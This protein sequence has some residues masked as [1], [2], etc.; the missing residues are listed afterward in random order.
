ML[1]RVP[2]KGTVPETAVSPQPLINRGHKWCE[3]GS[4]PAALGSRILRADGSRLRR[5]FRR[6]RRRCRFGRVL[7]AAG[8]CCRPRRPSIRLASSDGPAVSGRP[9]G[10]RLRPSSAHSTRFRDRPILRSSASTRRTF[11]SITSPTL[12]T[13][14]GFSTL[15]SASSEMCSS[16]PG[17]SPAR[18]RRRS[19]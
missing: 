13:S 16:P 11:T 5:L 7:E 14:S 18:R 15:W 8:R 3:G 12:T 2:N 17:R 9:P 1:R 19:W 10:P 4:G 6:R